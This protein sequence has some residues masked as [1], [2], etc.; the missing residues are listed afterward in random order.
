MVL[1]IGSLPEPI[2]GQSLACQVFLDELRL[3]HDV[4]VVNTSKVGLKQ[5]VDSLARVRGVLGILVAVWKVQRRAAVIYLAISESRAGNLKDLLIYLVCFRRLQR[6]VVHLHG[7]AGLRQ[8]LLGH[9]GAFRLA[10]EFFCRRLGG[11]IV[12]GPRHMD[13]FANALP[14]ERIHVVP[15][16][17]QDYLFIEPGEIHAKFAFAAPLR[18]LFLSNL[19]PGKGYLEL[20]DAFLALSRAHQEGLRIDFA[21]GFEDDAQRA[22]F[23]QRIR[24]HP[25][26]RYHG[27]VGG[28]AKCALFQE[29]HVFCLPTYYPYEGQ[30][31]SILEAYAAGCAVITTDHSGIGDVFRDEENGWQVAKQSVPALAT[32]LVRAISDPQRLRA[33]ALTNRETARREYRTV[34]YS[35]RLMRVIAGVVPAEPPAPDAPLAPT[36]PRR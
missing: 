27:I 6:M 20:L 2:T 35:D 36:W 19:I 21:G 5:G 12:L 31:I 8:I 17:A 25:Q 32:A 7:G 15:N 16:F 13:V 3:H 11:A 34:I 26:L 10:N 30:P 1:F 33:M 9:R 24:L 29:A 23:L 18:V 14:P 28:R 4:E 22:E